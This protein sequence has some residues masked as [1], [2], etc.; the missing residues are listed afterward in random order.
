MSFRQG[1]FV[2]RT[3]LRRVSAFHPGH[4]VPITQRS[5]RSRD[6][7]SSSVPIRDG[8]WCWAPSR[9]F[10]G[11]SNSP[12]NKSHWADGKVSQVLQDQ[13]R[14]LWFRGIQERLRGYNI[15]EDTKNNIHSY[16]DTAFL[17]N[18]EKYRH[19]ARDDRSS[20]HLQTACLVLA[21]HQVLLPFLRNEEEVMD[22]LRGQLGNATSPALRSML[23]MTLYF[24]FDA[25]ASTAKRLHS[26]RS[27]LGGAVDAEV[28]E[29][30]GGA[31]LEV[32]SCLYNTIF[33]AE[34]KPHLSDCCCCSLDSAMWFDG[35]DSFGIR[36]SLESRL[37]DNGSD[38]KSV[39]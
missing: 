26:L 39:V 27:D 3:C 21:T 17:E 22:L 28:I 30:D 31:Q 36:F 29:S 8:P 34:D 25:F 9:A 1:L 12:D 13:N 38:R 10:A 18:V 16:L 20:V 32:Y 33:S 37:P 24:S 4:N 19:L 23:K 7:G 15:A 11:V 2:A 14:K 5:A 6:D 35:L